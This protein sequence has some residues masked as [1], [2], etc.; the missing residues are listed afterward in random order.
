MYSFSPTKF[1][2]GI[3][4]VSGIVFISKSFISN[5]LNRLIVAVFLDN[6][7]LLSIVLEVCTVFSSFSF[8]RRHKPIANTAQQATP[9]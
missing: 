5:K 1:P 2:S 9:P 7:F 4:V 6:T 8:Y 3:T